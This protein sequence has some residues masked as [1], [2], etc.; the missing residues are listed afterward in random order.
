MPDTVIDIKA[1]ASLIQENIARVI[2]G[3]ANE[4]ELILTAIL[5]GGHVLLEIGRAH[6]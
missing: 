5:T 4:V 6:V 3:K 2:V 1:L